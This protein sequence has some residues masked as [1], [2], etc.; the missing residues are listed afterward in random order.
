MSNLGY[1]QLKGSPG[2]WQLSV[3]PGKSRELFE[4]VSSTG[5]T[6]TGQQQAGTLTD[7][8]TQVMI[9]SFSGMLNCHTSPAGHWAACESAKTESGSLWHGVALL[10]ASMVM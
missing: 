9:D 1:Y 10:V 5:V 3:A 6:A 8:V 2:L 7:N 4:L